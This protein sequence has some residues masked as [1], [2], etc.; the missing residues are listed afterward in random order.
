[1][2]QNIT[3]AFYIA[4]IILTV[5]YLIAHFAF[6]FQSLAMMSFMFIVVI[7][8][9]VKRAIKCFN[10]KSYILATLDVLCSIIFIWYLIS[11]ILNR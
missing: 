3:L 2:K 6:G 1:M 5:V 4:A 7:F 9:G 11:L 10:R 8:N